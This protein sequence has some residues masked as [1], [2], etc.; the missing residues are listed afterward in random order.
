MATM[1]V[2]YCDGPYCV[3]ALP[4]TGSDN[5]VAGDLVYLSGGYLTVSTAYNQIM[6]VALGDDSAVAG[7]LIPVLIINPLTRFR[8]AAS[9]TTT[10]TNCGIGGPMTYTSGS[11]AVTP[12]TSHTSHEE[13]IVEQ[14]DPRDGATTGVGGR[15][16]GRFNIMSSG[17]SYVAVT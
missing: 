3:T 8:V 9:A 4:T 13:F 16:I 1:G 17:L 10:Q 14:L 2:Q 12:E 6:A 7:T 5:F 15:V 11:V